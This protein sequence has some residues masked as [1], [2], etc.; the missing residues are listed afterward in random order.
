MLMFL[1]CYQLTLVI[2]IRCNIKLQ[3]HT[4]EDVSSTCAELEG[5]GGPEPPAPG[6]FKIYIREKHFKIFGVIGG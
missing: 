3:L 1:H 4:W 2:F 5:W 6:I